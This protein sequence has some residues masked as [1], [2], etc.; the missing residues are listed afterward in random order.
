MLK[1]E[2]NI[3]EKRLKIK[4]IDEEINA[5]RKIANKEHETAMKKADDS[6]DKSAAKAIADQEKANEERRKAIE[7]EEELASKDLQSDLLAAQLSQRADVVHSIENEIKLQERIKTIQHQTGKGR[8]ES[9]QIAK[10]L[11]QIEAGPDLNQSGF[12]TPLERRKW[13]RAQKKL[14]RE[15]KKINQEEKR[16]ERERGGNIKKALNGREAAEA[17]SN[18]RRE[19]AEKRE[20]D[21]RRRRGE[22]PEDVLKEFAERR[23]KKEDAADKKQGKAAVE[24]RKKDRDA[25]KAAKGKAPKKPENAV[26]DGLKPTLEKQLEELIKINK[27]LK[28][29]G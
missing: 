15:Q 29:D 2:K 23:R 6:S 4:K 19:Q 10:E 24:K 21:R 25:A 18:K 16:A 20:L 3:L 12:V 8:A 7:L 1:K 13:E 27:A 22:N 26:V 17:R 28:C 9:L 5:A 14:A 11:L